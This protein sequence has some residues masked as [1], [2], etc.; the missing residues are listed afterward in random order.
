M[1]TQ[2]AFGIFS[3][4]KSAQPPANDPWV[5][6]PIHRT[7]LPLRSSMNPDYI[8]LVLA[9]IGLWTPVSAFCPSSVKA[10]LTPGARRRDDGLGSLLRSKLN[11]LDLVRGGACAWLIQ[12]SVFQFEKGQDEL[13]LVFT[14]VKLAILALAV[15]AQT[16]RLT[17]KPCII[18][19]VFFLSGVTLA[20]SGPLV[21]GFA[22]TLAFTLAL[23]LRR[24][25]HLF[26]TAP[27]CLAVFG[28]VF[29]RLGL[30]TVFNA[31]LFALPLFLSFALGVRLSFVRRTD[32]AKANRAVEN[33]AA[34]RAPAGKN[35]DASLDTTV[36]QQRAA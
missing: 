13:A 5:C 19:P 2:N 30:T 18:G 23:M 15:L 34:Q 31:G 8:L 1:H 25:S 35:L 33:T 26:I 36:A 9:L 12:N 20:V 4:A 21:G 32:E 16:V 27:V 7:F 10:K 3:H 17:S 22:L 11:W 29:G 14:F 28:V 24:L 6:F